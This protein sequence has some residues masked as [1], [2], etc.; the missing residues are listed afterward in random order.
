MPRYFFH[1]DGEG[2][3][4][5]GH[6]LANVAEAKC[7]AVKLAGQAI[8]DH[9]D[10]FWDTGDWKMT[11]TNQ[12]GLTL[13]SLTFFGTEAASVGPDYRRPAGSGSSA[14]LAPGTAP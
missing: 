13:F 9:A 2:S 14:R 5:E 11:V 10:K 12:E 8:C 1:I 4:D 3:S 6:E 7:E